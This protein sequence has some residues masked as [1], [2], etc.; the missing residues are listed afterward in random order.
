MTKKLVVH[1]GDTYGEWTVL[2]EAPRGSDGRRR[3]YCQCSCGNKRTLDPA[4]LDVANR[5]LAAVD[6]VG[7]VGRGAFRPGN[8]SVG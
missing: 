2:F 4:I 3:V 7:E 6:R 8:R 1:P 5:N